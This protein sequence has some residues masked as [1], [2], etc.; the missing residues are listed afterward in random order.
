MV[1]TSV[2]D[3]AT[4]ISVCCSQKLEEFWAVFTFAKTVLKLFETDSSVTVF[5]EGHEDF[6][7]LLDIVGRGLNCDG[8]QCYLLY[9]LGLVELLHVAKVEFADCSSHL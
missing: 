9:L 2:V 6:F 4:V 1:L 8:G 5:I 3:S 7:E